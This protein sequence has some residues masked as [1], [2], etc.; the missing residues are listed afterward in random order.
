MNSHILSL[1]EEK[2]GGFLGVGERHRIHLT[3]NPDGAKMN[4]YWDSDKIAI[5]KAD[6]SGAYT[7]L[8]GDGEEFTDPTTLEVEG[9]EHANAASSPP[10]LYS[11]DTDPDPVLV[12]IDVAG[13][14]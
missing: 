9:I 2:I 3:R 13:N 10:E 1:S 6:G 5:Y 12:D 7:I 4:L 11:A 14:A 8:V